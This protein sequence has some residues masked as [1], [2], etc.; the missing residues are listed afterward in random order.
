[1]ITFNNIPTTLRT[2]GGYFEVDN[3]RAL[4][5]LVQNPHKVLIVAQASGGS[6]AK[7][8]LKMIT[9]ENK[10]AGYFGNGSLL[11]RMCRTFKKNNPYTELWAIAVSDSGTTARASGIMLVTGSATK[12]GTLYML[13]GGAQVP[14]AITSGWS[15][16]DVCSA[17]MS[18]INANS[19]LCIRGSANSAGSFAALTLSGTLFLV[20]QTSG[21]AGNYFDARVNFYDGQYTPSGLTVAVTGLAGG[22]GSPSMADVWAVVDTVQ[23]QHIIHPYVDATNLGEVENELADRFDPM[24]DMQGH[25]YAATRGALASCA[26]LGLTRNSPHQTII[27]AYD[28]PSNPEDWAAALGAQAAFN[29]NN[30]P[31][32]PL[33]YLTLKGIVAPSLASGNRF[34]QSERNVLLYDGIATWIVDASGNVVIERAITTYRTNTLGL[35]DP[36]YLD[37]ETMFTILEIRYQYKTRMVT[38]FIIPRFKLADDGNVY[39]AGSKIATPGTVKQETIALFTELR[40]AGLIENIDDFANNLVVE[41]DTTDVNRV[42][43]LLPPDLINQFRI[44]AGTIQFVL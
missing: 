23:F 19:Q 18:D 9:D 30:D 32:R 25:A 39:P 1:M 7:L 13:L 21:V 16:A 24:V 14:T 5:G 28:S 2:P 43:V 40:D 4:K 6:A 37:V 34:S 29:L 27:G 33:H 20:A 17:A 36:S 42:N 10:A 3:S 35:P 8:T 44:L 26:A 22:A 31:A 12:A 11:D 38:R 15:A 41:R